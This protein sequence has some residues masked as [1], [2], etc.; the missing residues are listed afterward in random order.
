MPKV[1]I[2]K[3]T[4]CHH[5]PP[6]LMWYSS[7]GPIRLCAM[8]TPHLQNVARTLYRSTLVPMRLPTLQRAE[9]ELYLVLKELKQR[10]IVWKP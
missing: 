3:P 7:D 1:T 10:W 9:G 5:S 2:P 4:E 8:A 6:H